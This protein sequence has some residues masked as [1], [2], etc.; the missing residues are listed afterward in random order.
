MTG[1]HQIEDPVSP[2]LPFARDQPFS[3]PI[4]GVTFDEFVRGLLDAG[5]ARIPNTNSALSWN[6]GGPHRSH[7]GLPACAPNFDAGSTAQGC[8]C[9][10]PLP[11]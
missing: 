10:Y 8:V 7:L 4:S 9:S 5:I 6:R 11:P 2:S 3:N 1:R